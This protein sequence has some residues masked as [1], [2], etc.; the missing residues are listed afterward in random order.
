MLW[1]LLWFGYTSLYRSWFGVQV[2]VRSCKDKPREKVGL[3]RVTELKMANNGFQRA[4][5]I[6]R[7]KK[8][9]GRKCRQQISWQKRAE[10]K[11]GQSL[12]E[13][14]RWDRFAIFLTLSCTYTNKRILQKIGKWHRGSFC[15][16]E[17][18]YRR[19]SSCSNKE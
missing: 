19:I 12:V 18:I 11:Q 1:L 6:S 9:Q 10:S 8:M 16:H 4:K 15:T 3:K 2:F 17:L 14:Y 7:R 5:E 13:R